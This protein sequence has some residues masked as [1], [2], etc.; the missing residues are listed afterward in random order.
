MGRASFVYISQCFCRFN[1]YV[2]ARRCNLGLTR[3]E[4]HNPPLP[5]SLYPEFQINYG[6]D[7]DVWRQSAKTIYLTATRAKKARICPYG[8]KGTLTETRTQSAHTREEDIIFTEKISFSVVQRSKSNLLELKLM[9]KRIDNRWSKK[10]NDFQSRWKLIPK[11]RQVMAKK[12][13]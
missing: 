12:D 9:P 1:G 4:G 10:K 7:S 13:K 8:G 2:L 5:L 6:S 11:N 3:L